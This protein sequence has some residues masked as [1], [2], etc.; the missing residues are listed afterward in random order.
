MCLLMLSIV[1]SA[2][3][4]PFKNAIGAW[5]GGK[6]ERLELLSCVAKKRKDILKFQM[7]Y[8]K[9]NVQLVLRSQGCQSTAAED[10]TVC[11]Q[12]GKKAKGVLACVSNSGAAGAGQC[13][14]PCAGQ[15]C[16][17]SWSAVSSSGPSGAEIEG[18]QRVQRR[19]REPRCIHS[20]PRHRLLLN[21]RQSSRECGQRF[22]GDS[23]DI[24]VTKWTTQNVS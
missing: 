22:V 9:S 3:I 4:T 14:V 20:V 12:V 8:L 19:A 16:G 1:W 10:E 13:P 18:L 17:R 7:L 5:R 24:F 23:Y 15:C 21:P 6:A 11:A 2:L